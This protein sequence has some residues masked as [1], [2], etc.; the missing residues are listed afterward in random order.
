M[1]K[2]LLVRIQVLLLSVLVIWVLVRVISGPVPPPGL[3]VLNDLRVRNLAH[4]AFALDTEAQ[5]A[6]QARGSVV[7]DA[8][9]ALATLS[10]IHI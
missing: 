2:R 10:L 9:Y 5:V 4:A 1:N 8:P 6:V 7:A 3:V